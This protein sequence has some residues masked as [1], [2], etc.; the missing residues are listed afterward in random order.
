MSLS[1]PQDSR[2]CCSQTSSN[3]EKVGVHNSVGSVEGGE[4]EKK[5]VI[6]TRFS[7]CHE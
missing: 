5:C 1:H 6:S 7:W 2:V 3:L 4:R